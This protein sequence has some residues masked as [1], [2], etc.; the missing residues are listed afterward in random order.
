M[1][2]AENAFKG[3]DINGDGNIDKGELIRFV[4]S[5]DGHRLTADQLM[6]QVTDFFVTFDANGDGQV[7]KDEWM[8]F[9][10]RLYDL[11]YE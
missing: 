10:S 8:A 11:T 1:L 2:A 7:Q 5:Y 9:F 4:M 3:F 6:A